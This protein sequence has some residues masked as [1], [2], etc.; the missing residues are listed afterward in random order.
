MKKSKQAPNI[1]KRILQNIFEQ[2]QYMTQD[3]DAPDGY[4]ASYN[5]A[6]ALIELLEVEDCGSVG[7][8]DRSNPL[9]VVSG[10]EEYDRFLTL[11][12]KE[13]TELEDE[14]YFTPDS[15]AKYWKKVFDFREEFNK[16]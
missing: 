9:K 14:A 15:M 8:F 4:A 13:Q 6:L 3:M 10:F 1:R 2:F 12:R 11:I 5:R 7:G 16:E